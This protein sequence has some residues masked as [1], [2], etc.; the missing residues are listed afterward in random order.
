MTTVTVPGRPYGRAGALAFDVALAEA[1]VEGLAAASD[2][3]GA[4]GVL[5]GTPGGKDSILLRR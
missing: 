4:G 5:T 3:A 1:S 2:V